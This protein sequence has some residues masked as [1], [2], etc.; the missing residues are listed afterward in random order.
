VRIRAGGNLDIWVQQLAGGEPVR[1]HDRCGPTMSSRR[2]LAGTHQIVF[3]SGPGWLA[4][5]YVVSAIGA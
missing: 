3:L 1:P 5:W 4:A 2:F